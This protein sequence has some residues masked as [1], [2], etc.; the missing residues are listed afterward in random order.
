MSSDANI[1]VKE[2]IEDMK[3]KVDI[4]L[5]TILIIILL[6][7]CGTK[8]KDTN[9]ANNSNKIDT[10]IT[11]KTKNFDKI[12]S[13]LS[14]IPKEYNMDTAVKDGCF[15]VN[16]GSVKSK[17][18]IMDKFISDSQNGKSTS[19]IIANYLYGKNPSI[20]KVIFDGTRYYGIE[21]ISRDSSCSKE[22]LKYRQFE[23]KYLKVFEE[24]NRKSYYLFNDNSITYSKFIKSMASSSFH[25]WIAHQY[26]SSYIVNQPVFNDSLEKYYDY[27]W[28][29]RQIVA[30]LDYPYNE[31]GFTDDVLAAYA[32]MSM[33]DY[34]Y[35][36]GNPKEEYD[37]ITEKYFGKKIKNFN[38]SMSE[39]IPGT[40]MVRAI[41]FSFDSIVYMILKSITE[42]PD[43]SKTAEF[44][45]L[46]ISDSTLMDF[47]PQKTNE[48]IKKDLLS[49]NFSE[50]GHPFIVKMK[51]EEKADANGKMYLKY[52][53]IKKAD[54]P[55][56]TIIPYGTK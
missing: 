46:N 13:E 32:I 18:E 54:V 2:R 30:L 20:K 3:K 29:N 19:I 40:N 7:G 37:A 52:L 14:L 22:P 43:G 53:E 16:G 17:F 23:F 47:S 49:G 35:E 24:N 21:D 10:E 8:T 33:D 56:D 34:S 42:E 1:I 41:G 9:V 44:Y 36:K 27:F 51:F 15:V 4:F 50:Y 6:I 12:K 11:D 31:N 39:V 38:N 55:V 25:A 45:T 28:A 26:L 48:E 5:C